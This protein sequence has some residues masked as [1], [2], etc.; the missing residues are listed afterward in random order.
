MP[1]EGFGAVVERAG[2]PIHTEPIVIDD[3]EPGEVLVRI[4]ASGLCH[5]DVWAIEHGNW[6]APWP[7]LL[8]HEGAGVV[9]AVGAGVTAAR[10]GDRVVLT[11]AVPCGRCRQ[12]L[13]G[14]PRRCGH[15]LH[16][17]PRMRRSNGDVLT[18][19]LH[20]GTLA[21]HSVVTEPQVVPMPDELALS[22]A[23]LLGCGV[24]TGVSAALHTAK[25]WPGASVAVIGLGGIGLA[26]LQGSR[27]A[28]AERLIG[29]D[30]VPRKLEWA[31]RFGA[32]D[33]VDAGTDDPVDAVRA[34]TGGEGV[35]VAFEA[36]GRP[37]CVRQAV[38]MLAFAGTAVAIGVPPLPSDVTLPWNGSDRAAYPKKANLL[39]TDGGDPIP[40]ED[41][42]ELARW[43]V[44]GSL[45]LDA[46]VTREI[47]LTDR[48]LAGAVRAML[49]GEVIRSV[50]VFR[51]VDG[52][53]HPA[54]GV[55]A[56]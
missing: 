29:V 38:E 3:P 21:T 34:V 24:S 2:A 1:T 14:A 27:I 17:P 30:V 18:G 56:R 52:S 4:A 5:S 13:R 28:G 39:M 42:P 11:W 6:G 8:G 23:C 45:D 46:M 41:F 44:A 35:D 31:L 49:D 22:R 43:A 26:A 36:V 32:T 10:P 33:T 19:V 37:E 40:S 12:C 9:E 15:E 47:E 54:A 7:M 25:V 50:V 48:D 16:Q 20:C 51:D 55:Q 53:M